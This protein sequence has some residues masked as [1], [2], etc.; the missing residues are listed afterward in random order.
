MARL[1][2]G[3]D[4]PYATRPKTDLFICG[5]ADSGLKPIFDPIG[6][7]GAPGGVW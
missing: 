7:Q 4:N 1:P 2:L 3:M 6:A 5:P